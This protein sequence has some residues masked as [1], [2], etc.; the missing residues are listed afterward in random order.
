MADKD[1]DKADTP[2]LAALHASYLG[3]PRRFDGL[4]RESGVKS[5]T[6]ST[7]DSHQ[8]PPAAAPSRAVRPLAEDEHVA[9]AADRADDGG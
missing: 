8:N 7:P 9:D 2:S 1:P 6:T 3:R 5:K 4:S